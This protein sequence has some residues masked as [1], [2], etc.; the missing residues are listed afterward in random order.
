MTGEI[1][2]SVSIGATGADHR[3]AEA[4]AIVLADQIGQ[5]VA[6]DDNAVSTTIDVLAADAFAALGSVRRMVETA[7]G[8]GWNV[9]RFSVTEESVFDAVM[10]ASV[11][12]AFVGTIEA[13]EILGVSKQRVS[14]LAA[15]GRMPTPVAVLAAGPVYLESSVRAFAAE[16][17]RA[18]RPK[19]TVT[20][21]AS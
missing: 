15:E 21:A 5:Y 7:L 9:E 6:V 18:G 3:T 10:E 17:R 13:A 20:E 8:R 2:W 19:A 4:A 14:Q 11:F 12:P 16:P 1:W